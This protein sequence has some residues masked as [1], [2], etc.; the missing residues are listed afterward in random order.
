MYFTYIIYANIISTV[1]NRIMNSNTSS[2]TKKY[3]YISSSQ[4][5]LIYIYEQ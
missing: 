5:Y 4:L 1:T 3:S 2:I